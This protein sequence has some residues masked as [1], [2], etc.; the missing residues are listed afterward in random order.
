MNRRDLVLGGSALFA[1]GLVPA[2]WAQQ[3][4]IKFGQSASLSGGQA[5]YGK[6]VRDGIAAAFAAASKADPKGP[7]FE[8]VSLDDG[9]SKDRC[10]ANVKTL[11]DQGV[12]AIIGLTSGAG[13][14]GCL[15]LVEEA[16]IVMLGTA[17]GNMGVRSEKAT[18][19]YHVRAGYADEYRRM[20]SY[21]KDFNMQRVGYVY[22]KDTSPANAA[23]MTAA[24]DAVGL[25]L[26]VSV[27]IDR[28]A[29]SFDAEVEKLLAA[30]LDCV[31]FTTNAGPVSAIVD[32]MAAA[33]Y[34]GFYFSSSFAGQELIDDMAGKGQ[35]IIMSQVVPRP[36]AVAAAVVKRC[37]EDLAAMGGGARMGFTSL[38]GYIAGRVAV[39]AARL[40]TKGGAISRGRFKDALSDLNV[41]L[42]GYRARFTPQSPHGS[43]FVDVVAIDRNGRIIG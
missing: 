3:A 30:R 43:R 21:V 18:M 33:K 2:V 14:E 31:L 25:K 9:G 42:G 12:T 1:A 10:K 5:G 4:V 27:P 35:S 11:I 13:A 37:Q 16:K 34:P 29:K 32:K 15:P 6:D 41:D 28:N 24:L 20:I 23:A 22:L 8:L 17:S 36:N 38:E 7:R 26:T 39:E 19:A 40:A